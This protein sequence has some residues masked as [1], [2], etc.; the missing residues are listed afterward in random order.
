MKKKKK[1]NTAFHPCFYFISLTFCCFFCSMRL[2]LG[3]DPSSLKEMI[4][5]DKAEINVPSG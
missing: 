3:L 4:V 5:P 2:N 1:E